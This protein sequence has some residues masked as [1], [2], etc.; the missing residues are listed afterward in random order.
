M[1][2]DTNLLQILTTVAGSVGAVYAGFPFLMQ[3]SNAANTLQTIA[4]VA[5][6]AVAAI[7][8]TQGHAS[9]EQKKALALDLAQT[10]L[11]SLH[12]Q[13]PAPFI[14]AAIEAA[15]LGLQALAPSTT[16]SGS[17]PPPSPPVTPPGSVTISGG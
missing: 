12:V 4:A 3:K 2:F 11:S 6:K 7:E 15:V 1:T 5:D 8:Q 17:S 16:T 10:V 13:A 9:G 14:D